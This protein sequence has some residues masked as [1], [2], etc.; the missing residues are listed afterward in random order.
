[1]RIVLLS[2]RWGGREEEEAHTDEMCV[3]T[4]Y[5]YHNQILMLFTTTRSSST[6]WVGGFDLMDLGDSYIEYYWEVIFGG[7][8]C[9]ITRISTQGLFQLLLI[10][11]EAFA[12]EIVTVHC[13]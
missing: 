4:A 13:V 10:L 6:W 3:N 5:S 9:S 8:T 11:V 2:M 12:R 1:M 7:K